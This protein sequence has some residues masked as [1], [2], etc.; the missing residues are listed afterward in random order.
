MK[1]FKVEKKE[2][3][4]RQVELERENGGFWFWGISKSLWIL[5]RTV[6]NLRKKISILNKSVEIGR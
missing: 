3:G 2:D 6:F 1:V 5:R 4:K